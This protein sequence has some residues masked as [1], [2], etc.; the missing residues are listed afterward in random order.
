L[1]ER[2]REGDQMIV[3]R[4]EE[5]ADTRTVLVVEDDRNVG[6]LL[7][8]IIEEELFYRAI[9]TD[10]GYKALEIVEE[11]R[12]HLLILDYQLPGGMNGIQLYDRLHAQPGLEAIPAL[13]IS[14]NAPIDEIQQ[15]QIHYLKKPFELN[16]LLEVTE[17]LVEE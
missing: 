14:A 1:S 7:V 11:T 4:Q 9:L 16:E 17:R 3:E 13:V 8:S 10:N 6:S 2:I 12:P 5:Q 15:R